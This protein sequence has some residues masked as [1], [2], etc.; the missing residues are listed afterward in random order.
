MVK[1][2]N[3]NSNNIVY[4][5]YVVSDESDFLCGTYSQGTVFLKKTSFSITQPILEP[6]SL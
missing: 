6:T 4:L 2:L 3:N 5:T 1:A